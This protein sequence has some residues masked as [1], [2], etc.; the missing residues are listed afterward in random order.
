MG[1]LLLL[2]SANG[3]LVF[4]LEWLPLIGRRT[5]SRAYQAARQYRATHLVVDGPDGAAV[6]LA[7]LDGANMP[8]NQVMHSAARALANLHGSGTVASCLPVKNDV[9]WVV[10]VHEGTVIAGTDRLYSTREQA[11]A[12]LAD[13]RQAFPHLHVLDI[14]AVGQGT[15]PGSIQDGCD[16]SALLHKVRGRRRRFRT[17]VMC[18]VLAL[19]LWFLVP[20]LWNMAFTAGPDQPGVQA[21]VD[22]VAA[23]RVAVTKARRGHVVHGVSGTRLALDAFYTLPVFT[24][25]WALTRAQCLAKDTSWNCQAT[26]RRSTPTADNASFLEAAHKSW[27]VSFPSLDSA[28]VSWVLASGSLPLNQF[29]PDSTDYNDRH[30]ASRFQAISSAFGQLQLGKPVPY[31]VLP[32][33]DSNGRRIARPVSELRHLTRSVHIKGPLRSAS[34]L[35]PYVGPIEW[36]KIGIVVGSARLPSLTSSQLIVSFE[37]VIHETESQAND[38]SHTPRGKSKDERHDSDG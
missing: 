29:S 37:G 1:Q 16:A 25:G 6:G 18:V 9:F 12:G 14:E 28:H 20:Q 30:L 8:G 22:P 34:L 2:P 26:Y 3:K 31:P 24:A 15:L 4:G 19:L 32:P 27:G 35:L 11:D 17:G 38:R 33:V 7:T 23:W 13:L 5:E 36:K 21:R 10:G